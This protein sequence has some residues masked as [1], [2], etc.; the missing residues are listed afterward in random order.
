MKKIR[1]LTLFLSLL[2]ANWFVVMPIQKQKLKNTEFT[3]T[4]VHDPVVSHFTPSE[5]SMA[6]D[7]KSTLQACYCSY[8]HMWDCQLWQW[9]IYE[10]TCWFQPIWSRLRLTAMR[11]HMNGNHWKMQSN[12]ATLMAS[13]ISYFW[14]PVLLWHVYLLFPKNEWKE[15]KEFCNF[16]NSRRKKCSAAGEVM[17]HNMIR[18]QA[19]GRRTI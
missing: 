14:I 4:Q 19:Y 17:Y 5:N 16:K 3:E 13:G 1:Y 6:V 8:C 7:P 2:S 10:C 11:P 12:D 18:F 9:I 15:P